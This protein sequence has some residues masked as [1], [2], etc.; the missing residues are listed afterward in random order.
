VPSWTNTDRIA[1]VIPPG[2]PPGEYDIWAALLDAGRQP[3]ALAGD[4]PA[5]QAWLGNLTVATPTEPQP[6]DRQPPVAARVSEFIAGDN[7]DFLG[8]DRSIDAQLTGD[9]L[10]ISLYWLPVA[11]LAP[12]HHLFLQLIDDQN[13]VVA[14]IEEPPIPWLG[15]SQWTLNSPL[16]S[17]SSLR[18]PA[19]LEP[20]DYDLIAGLFDPTS[21]TRHQ[22]GSDD[23]L[24]LGEISVA[25]R[26]HHF[27]PPAPQRPLDLTLA[28]EQQLVGYDLIAG[29][30]PGSPVNLILYWRAAGPTDLAY[31]TFVHLLDSDDM[32]L[33]Q[34]DQEPAAGDH[35][36]TSWIA[37]E[38]ITDTHALTIPPNDVIGPYHL[39]LGLYNPITG[40]RLP[41]IDDGGNIITDHIVLPIH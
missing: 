32:I 23:H 34:S 36:T 35:P 16:R 14:G 6:S 12:D 33:D 10:D 8:Y 2:T 26:P 24:R 15:T 27:D 22:W 37:G 5:P 25:A 3:L 20:G 17:Q 4:N 19:N 40:Q 29:D 21:A 13:Q 31:S 11:I 28:G 18:I 1:L 39:A 7:V 30:D 9:D 41:F 38:Y